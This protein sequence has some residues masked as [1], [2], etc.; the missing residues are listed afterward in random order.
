MQDIHDKIEELTDRFSKEIT[1]Q[2]GSVD[3]YSLAKDYIDRLD[4][5]V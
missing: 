5:V 2:H 1:V 3:A 4:G